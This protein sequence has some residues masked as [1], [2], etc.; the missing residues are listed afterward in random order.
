MPAV[1]APARVAFLDLAAATDEVRP[2]LDGA[3]ARVL[4][5]GRFVL[6]AEVEAFEAEWAAACG[7]R[8]AVGVGSGLDALTLALRA[9]GI[10][11]GDEVVV[12]A[13]TFVATWLAVSATGAVPVG[14]DV[15]DATGALDSAAA[16]AAVSPRTRAVVVVHL[17]GAVDE[18]AVRALRALCDREGL[19]LVEDAAQAHGA[20]PA[21]GD[22]ACWS[23]Y[24]GK[25]LGA[26]GDGGAVTTDDPAL[27]DRVR[28]LRNY[29]SRVKYEHEAAGVNSRLDELQAAVLR[30]KLTLLGAWNARRADVAALYGDRLALPAGVRSS[31][32]LAPL[33]HPDRDALR[34]ELADDGV[35]T[36]VHY[37]T[38][39][40]RTG[41]YGRPAGEF[42]V[43]EAW[44]R[45]EL[46]L[47]I[48][49]HLPLA[50]ARRVREALDRQRPSVAR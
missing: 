6:G 38:L 2:A 41:A 36:L 24:P 13:Q 17:F 22:V 15:L 42:P 4:S 50:D 7:A 47:P 30:T 25:N 46:S 5:S 45:E 11:P 31:W 28:L 18:E 40:S 37:P 1:A 39:P 20:A 35:E 9:A 19:L 29:G 10:G 23:F 44:A 48:G 27:A 12:P 21:G 49:P 8:H 16:T 43:A 26:L 14:A 32:H 34:H 3:V 33:R